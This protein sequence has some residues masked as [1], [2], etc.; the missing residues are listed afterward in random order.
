M[1]P[2]SRCAAGQDGALCRACVCC[3]DS[4][5]SGN[6]RMTDDGVCVYGSVPRVWMWGGK[7]RGCVR[8]GLGG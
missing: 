4:G 5:L 7:M 2:E 6:T 1:R 8:K 3:W